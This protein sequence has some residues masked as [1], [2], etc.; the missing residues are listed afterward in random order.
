MCIVNLAEMRD[1]AHSWPI[2]VRDFTFKFLEGLELKYAPHLTK[3]HVIALFFHPNYKKF[4]CLKDIIQNDDIR[5]AIIDISSTILDFFKIKNLN[6]HDID[7]C[8]DSVQNTICGKRKFMDTID[9]SLPSTNITLIEKEI[10]SYLNE[11]VSIIYEDPLVYWNHSGYSNLKHLAR[12]VYSIPASSAECERHASRAGLT[13]Q[14]IRNR[15]KPH[16]LEKLV[17]LKDFNNLNKL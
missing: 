7:D 12:S 3:A 17:F 14:T 1:L 6:V 4:Q 15:L 16:Q 8:L 5:N 2:E 10:S 11:P 9:T 13:L